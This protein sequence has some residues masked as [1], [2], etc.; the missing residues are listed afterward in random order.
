M[1]GGT[2]RESKA[3]LVLVSLFNMILRTCDYM[4]INFHSNAPLI[5]FSLGVILLA[6]SVWSETSL[7]D[8]D[9]H[10]KDTLAGMAPLEL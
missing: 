7:T 1:S 6:P 8:K 5:I 9:E 10:Q 4:K 3:G 2:K